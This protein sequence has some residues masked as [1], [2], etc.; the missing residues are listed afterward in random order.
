[1]PRLHPTTHNLRSDDVAAELA[2]R[3]LMRFTQYTKPDYD[4]NWHHITICEQ[5]DRFLA[6]EIKR[7]MIFTHPRAGKSELVSRRLPAFALGRDPDLTIITASYGAGLARR[8]NRDV[9]RII[10]TEEYRRLFPKTQ[11]NGAN[12]RTVSQGSWL[13]NSD[14]FEVVG[15]KGFYMSVGV[16]GSLTGSG[17]QILVID[18]PVKNRKEANSATFRE[19]VWEWYTS[20]FYTRLAPGGGILLTLTRW[21][22]D[23]L[24]GRLLEAMKSDP[25]ADQWEII[26]LPALSEEPIPPY[27]QRKQAGVPLW[28]NRWDDKEMRKKRAVVGE[29]DWA[30]LY[31]QRPAPDAG[32]ILKRQWW[33]YWKPKGSNLGP[34]TVRMDDGAVMEVD[35]VELPVEFD[36]MLQSWDCTFKDT[37][38]S[39]FVAGQVWGRKGANKYMV[40]YSLER[41]DIIKTM[42]GIELWDLK[43]PKAV[44]KIIEDKAN[45]PAVIQLLRNKIAGLIAV[46]PEGGKI[47]R[48]YAASPEVEAGNVY[49]PHPALY[50]WVNKFITNCASFPNAAHDDDVDTF[51]QAI[52]RW[53]GTKMPATAPAQV[54]SAEK[55]RELFG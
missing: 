50:P 7:L 23:D 22:E 34:V 37:T 40:D 30:S 48:A 29:R 16:G 41:W 49:L 13:R 21:H 9:Q 38:T 6:G 32:D 12:V 55:I 14:M 4:T 43:W 35:A 8:M 19:S 31:Q 42:A 53:Q 51:S 15:H 10:D 47:S 25:D 5:L 17:G 2:R 52:I 33:R 46:N 54:V 26:N 44:A 20:T 36:D 28:V 45:G 27:D 24:A 39:D 18:D 1:L 3:K 11:L